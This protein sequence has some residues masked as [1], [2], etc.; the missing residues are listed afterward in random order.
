MWLIDGCLNFVNVW[1]FRVLRR[2][3]PEGYIFLGIEISKMDKMRV[4]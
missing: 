4:V 2:R 1:F 3:V